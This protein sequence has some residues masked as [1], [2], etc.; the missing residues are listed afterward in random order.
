VIKLRAR[1]G[2]RG[3]ALVE[4]ALILPILLMLFLGI[5]EFGVVMMHQLTLVQIA[6]EGSRHASLGKPVAQIQA[7]ILNTGGALPN[8]NELTMHF[9]VSNN[10]GQTWVLDSLHDNAGGEN[11]APPGSLIRV[12]LIWPH[13]LLTGSFFA[14]LAGVQNNTLPL[15]SDVIMRR[16]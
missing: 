7:R 15:K 6:R 14:W 16:E 4:F 2:R 3:A 10:D 11:D 12:R 9:D 8:H 5:I 13:H 1:H